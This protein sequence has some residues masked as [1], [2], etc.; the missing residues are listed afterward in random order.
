[1]A[2]FRY[3]EFG[4]RIRCWR[5]DIHPPMT[6]RELAR[7]IGVSDGFLAHIETGRTLPGIRTLRALAKALGISETQMLQEAGYLSTKIPPS[8]EDL[9]PDPELRL[10]FQQDW[11]L[12][13]EDEK[14]WFRDFVRLLKTR[15]RS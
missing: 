14:E 5:Q 3:Q 15:H 6:Q 1:M 4:T 7:Q 10:F 13:S 9:L 8:D 2:E 11:K 12:L